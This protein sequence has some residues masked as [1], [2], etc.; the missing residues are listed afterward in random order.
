MKN[1]HK[2]IVLVALFVFITPAKAQNITW[3]NNIGFSVNGN[4]L[5]TGGK[6]FAASHVLSL[7]TLSSEASRGHIKL[8]DFS[9]QTTNP[10]TGFESSIPLSSGTFN[11]K[12]SVT[13]VDS[14]SA[15]PVLSNGYT[16]DIGK[17]SF[18]LPGGSGGNFVTA[19]QLG[20]TILN[21]VTP[22]EFSES[23]SFEI[24]RVGSEI[25]F[26]YNET[27]IATVAIDVVKDYRIA[28]S[29]NTSGLHF[30]YAYSGF[31]I[32]P[33]S[34][35]CVPVSSDKN[36]VSSCSYDVLGNLKASGVSYF[37]DLGKPIQS[38]TVNIKTGDVWMSETQYDS[39]VDPLFKHLAHRHLTVIT[40]LILQILLKIMVHLIL[41]NT[42][43]KTGKNIHFLCQ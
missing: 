21:T 26:K 19:R 33:S 16:L 28:I 34:Y 25:R 31:D 15:G 32:S 10:F 14:Y 13:D 6:D 42:I 2:I 22:L 5:Q 8:K 11:L 1:I 39:K 27:T 35:T 7:H 12:L 3:L 40:Y 24:K 17:S 9:I 4:Q 37:N 23:D 43:K 29:T 20:G 38:Q 36:W 41:I 18:V 30:K